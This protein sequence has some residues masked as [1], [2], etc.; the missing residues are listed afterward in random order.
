MDIS[1]NKSWGKNSWRESSESDQITLQLYGVDSEKVEQ[2]PDLS[3]PLLKEVGAKWLVEMIDYI[4]NH[5][6]HC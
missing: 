4:D 6:I 3:L 2:E 1:V 5:T